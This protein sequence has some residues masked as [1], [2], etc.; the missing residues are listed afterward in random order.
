MKNLVLLTLLCYTSINSQ[1]VTTTSSVTNGSWNNPTTWS[2]ICVPLPGSDITINH[3]ITLPNSFAYTSGTITI[4]QNGILQGTP[5]ND[6]WVNGGSLINHG[7][8][9]MRY[10]WTQS[11]TFSNDGTIHVNSFLN[12]LNF[13]NEGSFNQIDSIYTTG[14]ITNNG[15]F[16][17]IDSMTNDGHFINNGRFSGNLFTNNNEMIN[18]DFISLYDFTNF[19]II[20]NH[21][22]LQFLNS[23]WNL[24]KWKNFPLSFMEVN[25][26]VLN[27]DV[28]GSFAH[29]ENNGVIEIGDSFYNMDT[30]SGTSTGWISVQDSSF[31][32]GIMMGN[33]G[34][35]DLTPPANATTIV[36]F[37]NGG[38][39][40]SQIAFCI[41]TSIFENVNTLLKVYPN[42]FI[43]TLHIDF[44]QSFEY[45]ITDQTGKV[46]KEGENQ[47]DLDLENFPI[48]IYF[49]IIS[50]EEN[51]FN[52]LIS[53]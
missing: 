1:I 43:N 46:L 23:I 2:C 38:T 51:N 6:I 53:K 48:G 47:K 50:N 28:L 33:F 37:S 22:T 16:T 10:L 45:Q 44:N 42:P 13:T 20:E 21:D 35:C 9:S 12:N 24:G 49:L 25:K 31:N 8:I 15:Q 39:I 5:D 40:S 14:D 27:D 11:G 19:N 32:S 41:H 4:N 7:E 34:F 26:S 3:S 29:L 17:D 30:I 18:N 52:I 36:D